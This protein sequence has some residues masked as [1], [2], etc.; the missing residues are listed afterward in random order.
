MQQGQP[1]CWTPS[2]SVSIRTAPGKEKSGI[3]RFAR[4]YGHLFRFPLALRTADRAKA[5]V[6]LAEPTP[7]SSGAGNRERRVK[8]NA[9]PLNSTKSLI[10][11]RA[12]SMNVAD[13]LVASSE[14]HTRELNL[15]EKYV[16]SVFFLY[17][18]A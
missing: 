11:F 7:E 14:C 13:T 15:I 4:P 10:I 18:L 9:R 8:T 17:H 2:R 12:N 1:A 3:T 5:V 16:D 6:G